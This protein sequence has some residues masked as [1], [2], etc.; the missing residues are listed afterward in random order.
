[1]KILSLL[2]LLFKIQMFTNVA[3][4][5]QNLCVD[6]IIETPKLQNQ[7]SLH[8]TLKIE[9][10][11]HDQN[12]TWFVLNS[13]LSI[14]EFKNN[15]I[16]GLSRVVDGKS[17]MPHP[18][19]MTNILKKW[20][21]KNPLSFT[22]HPSGVLRLDE[23]LQLISQD[24]LPIGF[25]GLYLH[26]VLDHSLGYALLAETPAWLV[27]KKAIVMTLEA[28]QRTAGKSPAIQSFLAKI[29]AFLEASTTALPEIFENP[30]Q[31]EM[32]NELQLIY[33]Q[34][35]RLLVKAIE[36]YGT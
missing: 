36:I 12:G 3:F 26:D 4:A 23:Y 19:T 27:L 32:E 5:G 29:N 8:Q 31:V 25:D 20:R 21:P 7:S 2:F 10:V 11:I 13:K 17:W 6:S 24:Q 28:K 14:P 30:N 34:V 16:I 9:K 1:M 15:H 35:D 33:R 18:N 22:A